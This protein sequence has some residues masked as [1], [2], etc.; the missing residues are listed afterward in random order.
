MSIKTSKVSMAGT[1]VLALVSSAALAGGKPIGGGSKGG[2]GDTGSGI[3]ATLGVNN[4]NQAVCNWSGR[5]LV[6][7]DTA[8]CTGITM[9]AT[10]LCS[11]GLKQNSAAFYAEGKPDLRKN[12]GGTI[13]LVNALPGVVG[14]SCSLC[15]VGFSSF[16]VGIVGKNSSVTPVADTTVNLIACQ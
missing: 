13:A 12:G 1:L 9:T 2:G 16:S 11:D 15:S 8:F 3:S 5:G 4:T 14:S 6:S 7:A 10:Y